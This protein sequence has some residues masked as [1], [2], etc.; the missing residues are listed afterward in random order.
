MDNSERVNS[1]DIWYSRVIQNLSKEISLDELELL[2]PTTLKEELPDMCSVTFERNCNLQCLHCVYQ[3]ELSSWKYSVRSNLQEV[4]VNIV[5][6]LSGKSKLLHEGRII[7]PRHIDIF[8]E[9]LNVR[10]DLSLGLID[11][12]T[13]T[14]Y[15]RYFQS[16]NVKLN[17]IDLSLDGTEQVHN[18][19]RASDTAFAVVMNGLERAKEIVL[20]LSEG[21][22]V[23]VPF[24]LTNINFKDIINTANLI[25]SSGLADGMDITTMSPARLELEPYETSVAELAIA[26]EQIKAIFETYNKVDQ[27]IYF[28][29]YRHEDFEKLANVIGFQKFLNALDN[30]SDDGDRVVSVEVGRITISIDDTLIT[31]SPLSIW[32]SETFIVDADGANR[33]AYSLKHTLEELR[34]GKDKVGNDISHF[35]VTELTSQTNYEETYSQGV[36]VWFNNLGKKY[37]HQ[38]VEMMNRIRRNGKFS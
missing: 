11:N 8:R 27:K 14:K 15:I 28:R 30:F 35:T 9:A 20:P 4:I 5:K 23:N 24:T 21:G 26:W 2:I 16:Q 19:Q 13:Y 33:T 37:L 10:S 38:E 6:Q 32:P 36:D 1:T 17:W 29:I 7:T 31:Y 18:K 22:K 25:F 12:G 3:E 34:A